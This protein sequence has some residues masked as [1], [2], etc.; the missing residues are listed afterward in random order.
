MRCGSDREAFTVFP[1]DHLFRIVLID[2]SAARTQLA[3]STGA[4]YS[5]ISL[6]TPLKRSLKFPQA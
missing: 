4:T 3:Q 5:S 6:S 2:Q 1:A